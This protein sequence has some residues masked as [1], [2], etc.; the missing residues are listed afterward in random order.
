MD[1]N[2]LLL[3]EEED[4]LKVNE[5]K[6]KALKTKIVLNLSLFAASFIISIFLLI[7]FFSAANSIKTG[8]LEIM[9]IQSVGG[10][11]LEEAYYQ[12]LGYIYEGYCFAIK[13]LGVFCSSVLILFGIS[14]LKNV[15]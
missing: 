7:M 8:G 6:A 2:I 12:N 3:P 13:A 10:K 4:N 5:S 1:D 15:S 14:R 9:N 11:T